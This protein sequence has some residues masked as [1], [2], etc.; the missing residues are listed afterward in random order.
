MTASPRTLRV[1]ARLNVGGPARH[2]ILADSGLRARGYETMLV[3]GN[4]G[5][6]EASMEHLVEAAGVP[7]ERLPA[8]GPRVR[9]IADLAAFLAIWRIV[10]R[11]APAV[12]HTHTSKAGALGRL[13][14]FAA[15]ALRPPGRRAAIVHTYHGHVLEGYFSPLMQR[16]VR[17]T[18]RLL[19]RITDAVVVI[20]DQ[21]RRD[22]VE[23]FAVAPAERVHVVPLGLDLTPFFDLPLQPDVGARRRWGIAD[24]CFVIGYVGRLV[25]IKNL[26][27]LI[28]AVSIVHRS[29]KVMLIIA[30][31][32]TERA[33]LERTA[34]DWGLSDRVRFCGWQ[35]DL[36]AFYSMT[37][38]VALSSRNEG[39]PVALIEAMAAA[40]PVVATA[41]GGVP[42]A[43]TDKVTG[44]LV[45]PGDPR[46]YAAALEKLAASPEFRA[47]LGAAARED[48]RSRFAA[49]RLID[50]LDSLYRSLIRWRR[51]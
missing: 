38:V 18:E 7:H 34:A 39:T 35:H 41:V 47:S 33:S 29:R 51:R 30:G 25:R 22:I 9:G 48:V 37:D 28:E 4:T 13:A 10:W 6:G 11:L 16:L 32:G 2:V 15:N 17:F 20:S 24:G 19:G 46:A 44:L 12:V 21:Q 3:Y 50:D 26:P 43:I 8:L 23:R 14:A 40:R 42:D 1:I 45:P 5:A 27:L 36:R 49:A 31:D